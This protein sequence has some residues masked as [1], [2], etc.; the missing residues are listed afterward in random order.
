MT[1]VR[2]LMSQ[3][4]VCIQA[5]DTLVTVAAKMRDAGVGSLPMCDAQQRPVGIL[6]DR[7][8][9]VGS[10]AEGSDPERTRAADIIKQNPVCVGAGVPVDEALTLMSRNQIRRM[11]VIDMDQRLIGMIA[12]ADIAR[13]QSENQTGSVVTAISR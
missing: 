7:D 5:E 8:I 2:E 13:E 12:Q 1:T 4:P 6:T 11:P 3:N 9:V 10:V